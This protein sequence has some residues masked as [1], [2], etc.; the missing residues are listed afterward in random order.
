MYLQTPMKIKQYIHVTIDM[1]LQEFCNE[2]DLDAK[3]KNGLVYMEI[4]CRMYGLTA[5]D[6]SIGRN[7]IKKTT[8]R[9]IVNIWILQTITYSIFIEAYLQTDILYVSGG[10]FWLQIPRRGAC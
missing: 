8:P 3:A 7:P 10:L 9:T 2:Y 6:H 1:I 4:L 5:I